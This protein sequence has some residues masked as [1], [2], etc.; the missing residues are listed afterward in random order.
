MFSVLIVRERLIVSGDAAATF[1]NI[2]ASQL[3]WRFGIACDLLMHLCDIPVMFAVYVLLRP[4]HKNL[5]LL[6]LLFN[7]IQTAVLAANKLNLFAPLFLLGNGTYLN[8]FPPQQLQAMSYLSLKA[9]DYGFGIGLLFFG[10]VCLVNGYLIRK[11]GY[12]P[13]LIGLLLQVAGICYLIH[14]FALILAPEVANRLFPAIMLPVFIA[15]LSFSLWLII[16]GVN[17]VKWDE[18]VAATTL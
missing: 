16:K 1:N 11:S 9:H 8:A 18:R 3:L 10:F 12:F 14:N 7:L 17:M 15:E 4:T 2:R 5:A 6:A 13:R